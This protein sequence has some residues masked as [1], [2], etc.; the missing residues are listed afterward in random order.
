MDR[1]HIRKSIQDAE[2]TG[3]IYVRD[4]N[5][6]VVHTWMESGLMRSEPWLDAIE[7]LTQGQAL[8]QQV[9]GPDVV[10]GLGSWTENERPVNGSGVIREVKKEGDIMRRVLTPRSLHSEQR[11][12]KGGRKWLP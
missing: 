9:G 11:F 12:C 3:G 7:K 10:H 5:T 8:V 2:P 1:Q 6:F 4:E